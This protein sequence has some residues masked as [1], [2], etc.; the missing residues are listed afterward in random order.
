MTYNVL[1]F[2][3]TTFLLGRLGDSKV[4][5]LFFDRVIVFFG[6]LLL[7]CMSVIVYRICIDRLMAFQYPQD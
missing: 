6:L 3:F 4:F 7:T 2:D 1:A 5:A